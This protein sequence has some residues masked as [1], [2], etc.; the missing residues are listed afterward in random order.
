MRHTGWMG[1]FLVFF[2]IYPGV[3]IR[4]Y[5]KRVIDT[6]HTRFPDSFVNFRKFVEFSSRRAMTHVAQWQEALALQV[7]TQPR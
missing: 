6:T 4:Y 5:E 2:P 1:I 7:L 3:C